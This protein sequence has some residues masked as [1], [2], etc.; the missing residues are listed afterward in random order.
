MNGVGA[1][2]GQK[3]EKE[4]A[5]KN[6]TSRLRRSSALCFIDRTIQRVQKKLDT[7]EAKGSMTDYLKLLQIRDDMT[8]EEPKEIKVTWVEPTEK[9]SATE[10]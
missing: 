5:G 10:T 8:K 3:P 2:G 6:K 1:E 4:V 7:D 9:E